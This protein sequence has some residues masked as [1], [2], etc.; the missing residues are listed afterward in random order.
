VGKK[1]VAAAYVAAAFPSVARECLMHKTRNM[2]LDENLV[3]WMSN[4]M[5]DR[6][7]KM[8]VDRQEGG[9]MEVTTGLPQGSAVSPILFA[10]HIAEVHE[11]VESRVPGVRALSFVDDVT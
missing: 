5:T 4:F 8:A 3:E 6:R 10:I 1:K 7:V 9:E 2:G 11:F